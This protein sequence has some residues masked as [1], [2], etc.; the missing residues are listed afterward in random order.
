MLVIQIGPGSIVEVGDDGECEDVQVLL[1]SRSM[2]AE[3]AGDTQRA[4]RYRTEAESLGSQWRAH[5]QCRLMPA[6]SEKGVGE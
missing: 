4:R 2:R 5:K 1:I 6:Y 3:E